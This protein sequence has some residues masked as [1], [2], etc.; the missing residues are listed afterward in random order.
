MLLNIQKDNTKHLKTY[1]LIQVIYDAKHS[2]SL[3]AP[4]ANIFSRFKVVLIKI[5]FE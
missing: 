3:E 2:P 5:K 4:K 1:K